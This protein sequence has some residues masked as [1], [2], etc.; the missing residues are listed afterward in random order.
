[1]I[2]AFALAGAISPN[3]A[4]QTAN[5]ATVERTIIFPR[6][7]T[8]AQPDLSLFQRVPDVSGIP[9]PS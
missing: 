3:Q 4:K 9:C 1:M 5:E 6:K 7:L 8:L 2:L